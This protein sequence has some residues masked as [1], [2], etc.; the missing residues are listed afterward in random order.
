MQ[1]IVYLAHLRELLGSLQLT[2]RFLIR[3]LSS[4]M[5]NRLV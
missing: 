1:R 5:V 3:E 4:D 2:R